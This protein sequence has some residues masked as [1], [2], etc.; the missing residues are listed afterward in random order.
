[1]FIKL[2]KIAAFF[3]ICLMQTN[4]IAGK[5]EKGQ[6]EILLPEVW[7]FTV[8][9]YD[10]GLKEH[11]ENQLWNVQ[12]WKSMPVPGNWDLYNEYANYKGR[13]WYRTSF[14]APNVNNKHIILNMGEVG[15]SYSVFLNGQKIA[16]ITCGNYLEQFDISNSIK[17]GKT[18]ILTVQI[19]N[20]LLWGA[21]WN[22]G[23]IRRPVKILISE[24]TYILR[25]E[26]IAVP[27]LENG[28]AEIS[29]QV[30]VSN[31]TNKDKKFQ[32]TQQVKKNNFNIL[33][34][35]KK[36]ILVLANTV[37]SFS[38]KIKLSKSQVKLWHFDHPELYTSTVSI[39][40]SN[41]ILFQHANNFGI[42][43]I[44]TNG[45]Q[46]LLNGEPVKLAGYNWV[47]DD[48]TTG[49]SLPEFRYKQDIDMMKSAG[50]NMARISH[51]PLP[52]DVMDY[53][54]E[55]G[56]LVLAEFNNWPPFM[57]AKSEEPKQFAKKLV[58]QN[59]NHPCVFG[60][61]VGNENGNLKENPEVNNY[62]SSIISYIKSLDPSHLVTYVSNTA[63]FQDNDAA[64]YCDIIMINKYG[65]YEKAIDQ[66]K[67][68]FP[69]KAVFMSEYGSHTDNLIYDT[70]DNSSFKSLMVDNLRNREN[71]VGYSLWTFNDYRSTYQAPN[72]LT[73]T[74]LHQN[75]QWGIVD[76][77]RNK[78]RAFKQMQTF[79]APV[80]KLKLS[81]ESKDGSFCESKIVLVPRNKLDIPAYTL[82]GYKLVW[83]IRNRDNVNSAM[84][85]ILLPETCPGSN[86]QIYY[87]PFNRKSSDFLFKV[88]LLSPTGYVVSDT[89]YCF[90][91]PPSPEVK[92]FIKASKEAR[93]VF[94]KSELAT[95]YI[96]HYKTDGIEKVL[97]PTIDHYVDL[98]GL[99]VDKK[100]EVWVVAKN[101]YGISQPSKKQYFTPVAGYLSLPPIVWL[102]EPGNHS[103]FV[104]YSFFYTDSQYEV[105]YRKDTS[106]LVSWDM[107]RSNN[108]SLLQVPNLDNGKQYFFQIR[109]LSAFSSTQNQWSELYAVTPNKWHQSGTPNLLGWVQKGSELL[110]S[111][112]PAQNANGYKITFKVGSIYK[113]VFLNQ[114]DFSLIN[115]RL[116]NDTTVKDLT[117]ETI[118]K[119]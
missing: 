27:N 20:S 6:Q 108:F 28:S 87:V 37:K 44:E 40:L 85:F 116:D 54:D 86:E 12:G 39:G 79:Y 52:E 62:V 93:I 90:S 30:F 70:P 111:V 83:E 8:D 63:D 72:P 98:T 46:F 84:G 69:N 104:G 55:K 23:G 17:Y 105:R 49:S 31:T 38:F 35:E 103:F 68:R 102:T 119:I 21:Y 61:S 50:A 57:N 76:I 5:V 41:T 1:M 18:N 14:Q 4:A 36:E 80:S 58:E 77:Y 106:H 2:F 115:I 74:P 22:W 25:Q 34:A 60:W 15:M 19:D 94:S 47:A 3:F 64:Q 56:I 92:D 33:I 51:R 81:I 67:V 59:F 117:I 71:L 96:V 114:S 118:N 53:L 101:G 26:I 66:L 42:R 32:L 10:L 100:Y 11:W 97:K 107:I 89:S 65:G 24:P 109:K 113:S 112:K 75:R 82:N 91:A 7:K 48:R 99:S 110:L 88:S 95:E 13:A 45:S 16:D 29:T 9:P 43:K 78:K 73:T